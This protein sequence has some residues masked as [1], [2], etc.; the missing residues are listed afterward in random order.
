MNL[1]NRLTLLRVVLTVVF[2]GLMLSQLVYANT[3]ALLVFVTAALTDLYDGRIARKRGQHSVLGELMDPLADKVL[4]LSAFLVFTSIRF[5]D[6]LGAP[7]VPVWA[8][9]LLIVRELTVMGLRAL[10]AARGESVAADVGGKLKTVAQMIAVIVI[11]AGEALDHDWWPLLFPEKARALDF[12]PTL[13]LIVTLVAVAFTVISGILY[14]WK[15]HR[16]LESPK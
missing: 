2:I 8:V 7:L 12:L 5:Q 11:L 4:V 10:I 14:F 9:I 1:A 16:L 3:M 13:Y 6:P 15:H